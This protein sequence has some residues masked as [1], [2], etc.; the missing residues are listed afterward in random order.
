MSGG[1]KDIARRDAQVA[2]NPRIGPMMAHEFSDEARQLVDETFAHTPQVDKSNLP[3]FFGISFKHP[4]LARVHMQMG[5]EFGARGTIPARERELATLR[6]GWL[7]GAPFEW[8]AHV[9]TAKRFGVTDE[10]VERV[11]AGADAPGWSEHDRAILHAVEEL[12]D[13]YA[14]SDATWDI[15]AKS[16]TEPQL[17]EMPGLVGHYVMTA[18][19]QNTMR[20]DL[21]EGNTGLGRR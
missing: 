21:L 12:M 10:E 8:G 7:T 20:F 4:G 17:M 9:P 3:D 1:Y 6:V 18:M 15:L 2:G 16:W 5:I 19:I 11:T 14:I 13:D